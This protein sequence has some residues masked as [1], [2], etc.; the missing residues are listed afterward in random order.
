[1]RNTS[2]WQRV[3]GLARTVI[4]AVEFDDAAG[5]VV[6]SVRPRK[7]ARR[8]CGRCGRRAPWYDR[9]DAVAGG[10]AWTWVSCGCWWRPMRP[11]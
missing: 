6:V 10:G 8:R 7:G 2:L 5:A 4:E 3:L 1:V 11:G 9:G